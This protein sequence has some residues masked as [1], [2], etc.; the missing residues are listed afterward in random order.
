MATFDTMILGNAGK[1]Y[2]IVKRGRAFT[3]GNTASQ[4]L[5]LNSATA[6]GLILS[7]PV[8]SGVC[9]VI[10]SLKVALMTAPAGA[11]TLF[12]TGTLLTTAEA[13]T[14]HTTPLVVKNCAIGNSTFAAS[15]CKADSAATVPAPTIIR[16]IGG[17]PVAASSIT[18]P[19]ISD[20]VDGAL[21]LCPGTVISVQC[22]TTA[23]CAIC[24]AMW[25]EVPV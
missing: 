25:E 23:I 20:D 17:G 15:A 7:N 10:H 6:T 24:T 14:T 2:D 12:W 8:T 19:Y 18:P 1:Y 11:S 22:L 21:W 4:A 3:A 5:S 13:A 9:M 16:A